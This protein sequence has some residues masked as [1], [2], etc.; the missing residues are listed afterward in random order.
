MARELWYINGIPYRPECYREYDPETD[1]W[2]M[3]FKLHPP[4]VEPLKDGWVMLTHDWSED[5]QQHDR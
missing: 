4:K 2:K 3:I 5:E 1:S